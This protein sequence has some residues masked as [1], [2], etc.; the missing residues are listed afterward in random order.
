MKKWIPRYNADSEIVRRLY[1]FELKIGECEGKPVNIYKIIELE[2]Y[3][4]IGYGHGLFGEEYQ[5]YLERFNKMVT[6]KRN[7]FD[8]MVENGAAIYEIHKDF[9][10]GIAV[11]MPDE[12]PRLYMRTQN[13]EYAEKLKRYVDSLG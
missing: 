4:E 7:E 8:E 11:K 3:N 12:K 13:A 2:V 9:I 10:Y 5:K 6:R 1:P